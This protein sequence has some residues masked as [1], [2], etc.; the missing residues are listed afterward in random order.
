MNRK[1]PLAFAALLATVV[2][3]SA[4]AAEDLTP[5]GAERAGNAAGTI[6]PWTGGITGVPE[7]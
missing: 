1:L 7:G 3:T 5:V 4:L 2:S 6:P